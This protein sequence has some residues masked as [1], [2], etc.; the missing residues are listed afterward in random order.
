MVVGMAGVNLVIH[1]TIRSRHGRGEKPLDVV[2]D[3]SLRLSPCSHIH[4][5]VR[6]GASLTVSCGLM[7]SPS[8]GR[9]T[10]ACNGVGL[11]HER[12]RQRHGAAC[13][14]DASA[15]PKPPRH[16]PPAGGRGRAA[17]G[18]Y[19]SDVVDRPAVTGHTFSIIPPRCS[20]RRRV[21]QASPPAASLKIGATNRLPS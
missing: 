21:H 10:S 13:H 14:A 6:V 11:D 1:T 20:P 17:G 12:R 19:R 2:V 7:G 4:L 16:L 9:I 15:G 18:L 5:D 8:A 3:G